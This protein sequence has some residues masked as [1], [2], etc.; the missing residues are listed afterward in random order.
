MA[1]PRIISSARA[2]RRAAGW[3]LDRVASASGKS[4]PTVYAYELNPGGVSA[5]TQQAL[6]PLYD[7]FRRTAAESLSA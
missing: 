1:T 4:R 3:S 5:E 6:D 7:S 2:A